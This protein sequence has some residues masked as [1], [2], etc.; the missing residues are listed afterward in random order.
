MTLNKIKNIDLGYLTKE[1]ETNGISPEL[2]C[3]VLKKEKIGAMNIIYELRRGEIQPKYVNKLIGIYENAG[4]FKD[5]GDLSNEINLTD[6]A[7]IN[8][9]KAGWLILSENLKRLK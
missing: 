2:F 9:E 1:V 7:I 8:Y 5:A 4:Q 3:F 6:N